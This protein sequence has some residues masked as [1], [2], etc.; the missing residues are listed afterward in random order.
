MKPDDELLLYVIHGVLHLVGFDDQTPAAQQEM[1][2]AE[3]QYLKQL[4]VETCS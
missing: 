4:G 2:C 3:R 1:R